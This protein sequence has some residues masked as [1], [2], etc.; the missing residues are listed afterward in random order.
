MLDEKAIALPKDLTPTPSFGLTPPFGGLRRE[1]F[2]VRGVRGN[3]ISIAKVSKQ[4]N[5]SIIS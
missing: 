4:L 2:G 3:Y 5:C 1:P